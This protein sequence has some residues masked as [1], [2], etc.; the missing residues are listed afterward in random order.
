M[1]ST[2]PQQEAAHEPKHTC[3]SR[4]A[5]HQFHRCP[6]ARRVQPA[7]RRNSHPASTAGRWAA[8]LV[9]AAGRSRS[10]CVRCCASF[11][12]HA[13][14]S[15]LTVG[16]RCLSYR[17]ADAGRTQKNKLVAQ[18]RWICRVS[19]LNVYSHVIRSS[20]P[21][22]P[23]ALTLKLVLTVLPLETTYPMP[24]TKSVDERSMPTGR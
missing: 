23:D 7:I 1:H 3:I 12:S 15:A 6:G 19:Y 8:P 5:L 22:F 20:E 9:Q 24:V 2:H 14:S 17:A 11:A 16:V 18:E 13:F 10:S 21:D 4:G